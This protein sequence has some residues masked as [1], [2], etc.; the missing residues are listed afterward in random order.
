MSDENIKT[1]DP[2]SKLYQLNNFEE[3]IVVVSYSTWLWITI[4][5][6]LLVAFIIWSILGTISVQATGKGIL[7]SND[8][9]LVVEVKTDG[10]VVELPLKLGDLVKKGERIARVY[11]L[12]LQVELDNA[13]KKLEERKRGYKEAQEVI[14]NDLAKRDNAL[15]SN[16][17]STLYE[18]EERKKQLDYLEADLKNKIML[19][20]EGLISGSSLEEAR[21]QVMNQKIAIKNLDGKLEEIE[22]DLNKSFNYDQLTMYKR[23]YDEALLEVEEMEAKA[24]SFNI[25]APADGKVLE[26]QVKIGDEIEKGNSVALIEKSLSVEREY[27]FHAYLPV[28]EGSKVTAGM[29]ARIELLMVDPKK[30]G[31]LIGRVKKVSPYPISLNYL[32][33]TVRFKNLVE[34]FK[35]S[36][37]TVI[38]AII[39]LESNSDNPSGYE[40]SSGKGPDIKLQ[41]GFLGESLITV[42]RKRPI[43]Y[44]IPEWTI[45]AIKDRYSG[46]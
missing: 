12:K 10:E 7:L 2:T 43:S 21:M 45:G 6:L 23:L 24:N 35:G 32:E 15:H 42:E 1:A 8:G 33:A 25:T 41:T 3:N 16:R 39:Q 9:L 46:E 38:E 34:F 11:D 19:H 40:W 36:T 18:L 28:N 14:L 26:L 20:K 31:Y 4:F 17:T 30:Y 5:S 22:G 44:L 27:L 29:K 13:K 37:P